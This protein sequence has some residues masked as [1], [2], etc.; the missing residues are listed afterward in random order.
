[1]GQ[2]SGWNLGN[3]SWADSLRFSETKMETLRYYLEVRYYPEV[4]AH[5]ISA[6]S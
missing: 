1:M 5:R 3:K 6:P 2:F 4:R